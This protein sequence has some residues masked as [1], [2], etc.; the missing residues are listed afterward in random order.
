M[1]QPDFLDEGIAL[2]EK[3]GTSRTGHRPGST[4]GGCAN[5]CG[6]AKQAVEMLARGLKLFGRMSDKQGI[7][8]T[9]SLLGL[10]SIFRGHAS[11]APSIRSEAGH[12]GNKPPPTLF[13]SNIAPPNVQ[14]ARAA[15]IAA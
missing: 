12:Q 6:N 9:L 13:R 1:R 8:Y 3:L 4:S 15:V 7:A 5:D 10:A 14:Q 2:F 11:A